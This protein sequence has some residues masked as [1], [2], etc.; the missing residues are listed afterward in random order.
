MAA[1]CHRHC[2]CIGYYQETVAQTSQTGNASSR[3]RLY[4]SGLASACK[5]VLIGLVL[6]LIPSSG[7]RRAK[8]LDESLQVEQVFILEK[9]ILPMIWPLF[10]EAEQRYWHQI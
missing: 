9:D 10:A 4:D 7:K 1:Y 5:L 6:P 8:V 2:L 3:A